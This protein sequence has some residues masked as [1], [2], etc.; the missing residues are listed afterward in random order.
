M[1]RAARRRERL[2]GESREKALALVPNLTS[3]CVACLYSWLSR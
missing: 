2:A 1:Q 3:A